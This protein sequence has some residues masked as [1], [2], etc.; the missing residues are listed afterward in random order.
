MK[1]PA[2]RPPVSVIVPTRNVESTVTKALKSIEKQVYPIHEIIVVDNHS[3]DAT[4]RLID[5]YSNTSKIPIRL[6]RRRE[7]RGIGASY[8]YGIKQAT[9]DYVVLMHSDSVLQTRTELTKLI[10]I[11]AEL[12]QIGRAHV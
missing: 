11:S 5:A 12:R 3:N 2:R 7:N 9:T 4:V 1:T 10:V 6:T 8:N